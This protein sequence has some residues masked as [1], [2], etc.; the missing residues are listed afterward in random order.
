MMTLFIDGEMETEI[1]SLTQCCI[2]GVVEPTLEFGS[3]APATKWGDHE[4]G[5]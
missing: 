4:C 1:K 5:N 3:S 2:V